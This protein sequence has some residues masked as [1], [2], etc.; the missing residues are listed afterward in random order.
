MNECHLCSNHIGGNNGDAGSG[1]VGSPS[2]NKNG[3]AVGASLNT[4]ESTL[5]AWEYFGQVFPHSPDAFSEDSVA[6]FSAQGPTSDGRLKP[7]IHAPGKHA[8]R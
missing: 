3:I 6:G 7:D 5:E 1:T 4:L 8:K 2:T